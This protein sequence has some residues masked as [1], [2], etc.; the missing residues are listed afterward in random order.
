MEKK[1]VV[2]QHDCVRGRQLKLREWLYQARVTMIDFCELLGIN[3]SYLHMLMR[4]KKNPSKRLVQLIKE[5]TKGKVSRAADI[6]DED[7]KVEE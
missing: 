1:E 5:I 3:R 2:I 4:G 7:I 6:K